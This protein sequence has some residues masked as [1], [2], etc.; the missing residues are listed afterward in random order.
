MTQLL[1]HQVSEV[2]NEE[3]PEEEQ[4]PRLAESGGIRQGDVRAALLPDQ[5]G[6]RGVG[7]R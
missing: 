3:V 5:S 2:P 6:R 4:P 7:D 1:S